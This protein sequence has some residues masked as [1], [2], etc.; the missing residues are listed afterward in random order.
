[1]RLRFG[2][3]GMR[4]TTGRAYGGYGDAK[5]PAVIINRFG[6]G[7]AIMLNCVLTITPR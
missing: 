4:L 5:S 2:E 6:K 3:K 1:M 7:K